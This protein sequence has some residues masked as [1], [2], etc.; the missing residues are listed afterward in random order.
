MKSFFSIALLFLCAPLLPAQS[1]PAA[2]TTDFTR[3]GYRGT[4]PSPAGSTLTTLDHTGGADCAAAINSAISSAGTPTAIYLPAGTYL[5]R[6]TLSL[7][8]GVVLRGAGSDKTQLNF[9][10]QGTAP[11]IAVKGSS[12]SAGAT[13]TVNA[14]RGATTLSLNSVSNITA[15]GVMYVMQNPDLR[16]YDNWALTNNYLQVVHV[17]SV[18]GNTVTL[19]EPLREAYTTAR[20]AVVRRVTPVKN[21]G[22]EDF[23]LVCRT[24]SFV[25]GTPQN[26]NIAIDYADNCWIT[27]IEGEGC[28]GAHI[29]LR[30]S[31]NLQISGCYFHHGFDYGGGGSAYGVCL[32]GGASQVLVANT[33][34]DSLRH[35]ML[36]QAFSSGNVFAYNYSARVHRTDFTPYDMPGDIVLHGNYAH[37]NLFQGNIANSMVIDNPHGAN[38]P[39]NIFLRNRMTLY[40]MKIEDQRTTARAVEQKNAGIQNDSTVLIGNEITHATGSNYGAYSIFGGSKGNLQY[41]N[42]KQGSLTPSGSDASAYKSFYNQNRPLFWDIEDSWYAIGSPGACY[43]SADIPAKARYDNRS[44]RKK[45]DSRKAVFDLSG[46]SFTPETSSPATVMQSSATYCQGAEATP[47]QASGQQLKWYASPTGG[48]ASTL[49]PTPS[50]AATGSFTFYVS[51]T[52]CGKNESP[53][54]AITVSVS[55]CTPPDPPGPD[56]VVISKEN[57]DLAPNSISH[58]FQ[59]NLHGTGRVEVYSLGGQ[60]LLQS[61]VEQTG[62]F[63]LPGAQQCVIRIVTTDGRNA[64]FK[65]WL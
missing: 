30:R 41:G 53:R 51:Q 54:T 60:L 47:L 3:A 37:S 15:G 12:P 6:N 63:S 48:T 61:N 44:L 59:L 16:A 9:E 56:P 62:A 24:K 19:E 57:I 7:K 26:D 8:S 55:A 31:V 65:V 50:T 2:Y 40:G 42:L 13:L 46:S 32:T 39:R 28:N 34:F 10:V 35:A 43:N 1:L 49:T 64:S 25:D 21:A 33:I 45:T 11:L 36:I 23:K 4:I 58:S 29:D 5:V 22:L 38:G 20:S 27:G 14:A 52:Q 17:K 18:S